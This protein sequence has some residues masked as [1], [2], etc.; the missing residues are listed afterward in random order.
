MN[1]WQEVFLDKHRR[2]VVLEAYHRA[3]QYRFSV[4]HEAIIRRAKETQGIKSMLEQPP[5][6]DK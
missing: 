2:R 3:Q 5:E 4:E 6:E 1:K